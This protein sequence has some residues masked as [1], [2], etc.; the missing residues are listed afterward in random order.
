MI[1]RDS[2]AANLQA[3]LSFAIAC[4]GLR[5]AFCVLWRGV[6][7]QNL[8]NIVGL[9]GRLIGLH[10]IALIHLFCFTVF[11]LSFPHPLPATPRQAAS[12]WVWHPP[13]VP[14]VAAVARSGCHHPAPGW[15]FVPASA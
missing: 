9:G 5:L 4:F 1:A 15:A 3:M 8:E 13:R 14:A 10:L 6:L 2:V 7:G 12:S 11:R